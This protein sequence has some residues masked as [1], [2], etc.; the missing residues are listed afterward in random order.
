M[1][2][3]ASILLALGLLAFSGAAL[4]APHELAGKYRNE[5]TGYVF[6][7]DD[8]GY[9]VTDL[10]VVANTNYGLMNAPITVLD[11]LRK[12]HPNEPYFANIEVTVGTCVYSSNPVIA[13]PMVGARFETCEGSADQVL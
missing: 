8:E 3:P 10:Q 2:Q 12:Y 5:V 6:E 7:I 9:V 13:S 4:A 11:R 1:K